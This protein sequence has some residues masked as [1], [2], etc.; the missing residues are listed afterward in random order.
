MNSQQTATNFYSEER[1]EWQ[2]I[3]TSFVQSLIDT[4]SAT[5]TPQHEHSSVTSS[6]PS[7]LPSPWQLIVTGATGIDSGNSLA[8]SGTTTTVTTST[9]TPYVQQ[10]SFDN[11]LNDFEQWSN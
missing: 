5:S 1:Y 6:A 10:A 8:M 2:E 7:A 9:T 11:L 4:L 3:D